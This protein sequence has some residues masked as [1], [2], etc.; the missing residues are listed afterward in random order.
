MAKATSKRKVYISTETGHF[1]SESYAK[2]YPKKARA[3]YVKA[4]VPW[5]KKKKR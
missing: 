2:R 5:N 4:V 3:S 1:V